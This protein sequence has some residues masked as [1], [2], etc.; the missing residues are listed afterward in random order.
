MA[1]P[2]LKMTRPVSTPLRD[3]TYVCSECGKEFKAN[4]APFGNNAT[5]A[6][7]QN[8]IHRFNKHTEKAHQ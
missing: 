2:E 4:V 1:R 6:L 8:M 3:Q 7:V 5:R